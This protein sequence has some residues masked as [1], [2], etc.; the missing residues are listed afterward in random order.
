MKTKADLI[1]TV[2]ENTALSKSGV[3]QA[4]NE[5]FNILV[6]EIEQGNPVRVYELGT[7]KVATRKAHK[8]RNPSTGEQ[9]DVPQKY[10]PQLK[11]NHSISRKLN[12]KD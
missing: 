8:G 5:F 12:A 9:I 2:C 10:V 4:I 3:E 1:K 7:F 11:F 6:Q